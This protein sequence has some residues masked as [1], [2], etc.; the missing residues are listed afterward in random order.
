MVFI[1]ALRN[2]RSR[3]RLKSGASTPINTSGRSRM[4]CSASLV[5]MALNSRT[6][7]STSTSPITASFS[8]GNRIS[9]PAA[10]RFGPPMPVALT[11]GRYCLISLISSEAR[12]SPEGSPATIP[13]FTSVQSSASVRHSRAGGNPVGNKI[14]YKE[15]LLTGFPPARE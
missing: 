2:V 3:P 1:P 6:F 13:I 4:K 10:R 14:P 8:I 9:Q 5:R 11:S 12:K 15:C 7:P